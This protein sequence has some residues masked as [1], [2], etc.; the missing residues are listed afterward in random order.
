MIVPESSSRSMQPRISIRASTGY[1][2]CISFNKILSE[3]YF[4]NKTHVCVE[5]DP[6]KR[7][8]VFT[9]CSETFR[10]KNIFRLTNDGGKTK[11][12]KCIWFG[13]PWLK[14]IEKIPSGQ[15]EIKSDNNGTLTIKY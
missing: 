11:N 15:F 6:E 5:I 10:N 13:R 4:Y 12:T 3:K 2:R 8:V 7:V 14:S 9:P 1:Q